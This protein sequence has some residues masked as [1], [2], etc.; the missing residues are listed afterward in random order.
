MGAQARLLSRHSRLLALE[1]GSVC[2]AGAAPG[3]AGRLAASWAP[4]HQATAP[5]PQLRQPETS[6]DSAPVPCRI[7]RPTE[8]GQAGQAAFSPDL[9]AVPR[10]GLGALRMSAHPRSWTAGAR[11]RG[12]G[13]SAPSPAPEAPALPPSA[14]L[15]PC[16]RG[17]AGAGGKA[18]SLTRDP[19]CRLPPAEPR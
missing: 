15:R 6:R 3:A 18:R 1:A 19:S 10:P 16:G 5:A 2:M 8:T 13:Q 7:G 17:A 11:A 4:T 14:V 12:C 9:V